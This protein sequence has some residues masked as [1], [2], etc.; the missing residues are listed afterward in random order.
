VGALYAAGLVLDDPHARA[1]ATEAVASGLVAAGLFQPAIA[2]VV[3]RSRPR[4]GLPAH[5]FDPF[6]GS[7]S[8]PSGHTTA[9]FAA[10][11]V[12]AAE[13]GHPAV[14]VAAYG[15]ATAVGVARMYAGAHFLSDVA[16]AALLGTAVGRSVARFGRERREGL[17]LLPVAGAGGT[18]LA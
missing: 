9:A 5:S 3:G 8:F 18:Y 10:A 7:I 13:Y 6:S 4:K 14:G 12:V 2:E 11:S 15:L 16:A 17:R 1:V